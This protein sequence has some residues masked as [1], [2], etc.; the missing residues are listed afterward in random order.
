[1]ADWEETAE[2]MQLR[3]MS[4]ADASGISKSA[5]RESGKPEDKKNIKKM[6][7]KTGFGGTIQ[8]LSHERHEVLRA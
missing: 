1:M 4:I 7:T 8:K 2:G 3:V 5:C 6:L